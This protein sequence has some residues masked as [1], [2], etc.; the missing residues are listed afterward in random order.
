MNLHVRISITSPACLALL[1]P[2]SPLKLPVA[3]AQPPNPCEPQPLPSMPC[4]SLR[5]VYS[6]WLL[7]TASLASVLWV[8][9]ARPRSCR[10]CPPLSLVCQTNS[11]ATFQLAIIELMLPSV[12]SASPAT[13]QRCDASSLVTTLS[14]G[15]PT[16]SARTFTFTTRGVHFKPC[17]LDAHKITAGSLGQPIQA[18]CCHATPL[19]CHIR[20]PTHSR[21]LP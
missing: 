17:L 13:P 15:M 14:L 9:D 6:F 19:L 4:A 3:T 20:Y 18:V 7:A 2:A 8:F 5:L 21:G 10:R 1:R 12:T 11:P 16:R